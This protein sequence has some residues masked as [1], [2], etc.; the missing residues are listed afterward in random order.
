MPIYEYL[1]KACRHRFEH[2]VRTTSPDPKCPA[3]E[4]PDLEQLIS[5]CAVQSEGTSEAN[6]RA[7]H[8]KV[9]AKR[10]GRVRDEHQH[11]HEHFDD[12]AT[13]TGQ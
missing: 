6:L 4:S 10:E 11:L 12:S 2:L 3:C 1:C 13:K 8:R 9:A 5:A 7:A